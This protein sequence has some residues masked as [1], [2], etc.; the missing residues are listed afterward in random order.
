M[1]FG[2]DNANL[3]RN[4]A[5]YVDRILHGAKPSDLTIA[6]PT[7]FEL[8]VNLKA[9]KSIGLNV[10]KSLIARAAEVIQ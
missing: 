5:T 1:A 4:A 2:A 8:V 9:A 3:F 7:K 6:F 10:P